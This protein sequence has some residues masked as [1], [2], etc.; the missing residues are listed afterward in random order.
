MIRCHSNS[1]KSFKP[2]RR[3]HYHI[4]RNI[5]LNFSVVIH[6]KR[7]LYNCP[8]ENSQQKVHWSYFVVL[9]KNISWVKS[10][11]DS[12]KYLSHVNTR[13]RKFLMEICGF[14][15][16]K[17]TSWKTSIKQSCMSHKFIYTNSDSYSPISQRHCFKLFRDG[18]N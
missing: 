10:L 4:I 17:E 15:S 14:S 12:K 6:E 11:N 2:L 16:T 8:D 9:K 1:L 7:E 5:Q 18:H 13:E 3:I